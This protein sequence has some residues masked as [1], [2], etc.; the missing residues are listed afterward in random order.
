[1]REDAAITLNAEQEPAAVA[2]VVPTILRPSLL[3]AARSVFR[4]N[5]AER[6]HLL[7]G[8]DVPLGDRAV[9]DTIRAECPPHVM[10][11]VLEPEIGRAHV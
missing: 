3:R 5:F 6:I 7:I 1:M 9:L 8:I 11:T 4:Q 10:L 2:V